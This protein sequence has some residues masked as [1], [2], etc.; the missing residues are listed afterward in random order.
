MTSPLVA[1]SEEH[2]VLYGE[3]ET[4]ASHHHYPGY[5]ESQCEFAEL[6]HHSPPVTSTP[7]PSLKAIIMG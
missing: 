1:I 6:L 7:L 2:P 3:D 5:H 4:V